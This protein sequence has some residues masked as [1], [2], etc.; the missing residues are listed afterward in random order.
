MLR[1]VQKGTVAF[2]KEPCPLSLGKRHRPLDPVV[3]G[4]PGTWLLYVAEL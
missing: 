4:L 1:P 3:S 2:K